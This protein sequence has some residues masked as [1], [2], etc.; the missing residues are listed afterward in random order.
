LRDG[1][2][3]TGADGARKVPW[4]VGIGLAAL[5]GLALRL[6]R[7]DEQILTGDELHAV[8][9]ALVR[10]VGEIL[11]EWSWYGADYS[12]PLTAFYRLLLDRGVVLSELGF[13]A[14]ILA[15]GALLPLVL[16]LA[17]RPRL[18]RA[19]ALVLAWLLA[20]S[21]M[22][23]LYSRIVRSYGPLVLFADGAVLAFERWWR[24]GRGGAAALYVL[25]AA[26]AVYLHLGTAPFVL[27]P[28]VFAAGSLAR[29][30]AGGR[31]LAALLAVGAATAATLCAFLL[32]ALPSLLELA[33]EHGRGRLP[34]LGAALDVLR[35][36]L[37]T[38]SLP[39][40]A[41]GVAL[42]LRGAR[43]LLRRDPAWL[44]YLATLAAGL[45]AGLALLAPNFLEAP[46]VLNRYLLPLLPFALALVAVGAATPPAGAGRGARRAQGAAVAALLLACFATGPLAGPEYRWSSFTHAQPFLNFTRPGDSV[47]LEEVPAFYRELPAG[48]EPLV[49]APWMNVGTHSFNAYQHVH[50]RPL[51]VVSLVRLHRDPRLRLRNVLPVQPEALLES[52]ARYVVVHLDVREEELRV[53]TSELRHRERIERL[54]ELWAALRGGAARLVLELEAAFG[55]PAYADEHVRAWDLAA[56]RDARP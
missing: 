39:L 27:A 4:T 17:L 6:Y 14:P 43:I 20:L 15:A 54:P 16:P 11:R 21:P 7:V 47:P 30:R 34:G 2:A 25:L 26:G 41:L 24:T 36:Q 1:T 40:A 46:V 8:N 32:P 23:V 31:R 22:L 29:R 38:R 9:A 3:Q 50:R 33:R 51:R 56:V 18:G 37:G 13:R 53:A 5:A 42:G 45:V 10:G 44:A 12:V 28:F 35:L 52:G 55:P 49:E 19:P 48:D